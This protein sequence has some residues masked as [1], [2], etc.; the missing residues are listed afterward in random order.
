VKTIEQ[1][2][3]AIVLVV[4]LCIAAFTANVFLALQQ[5]SEPKVKTCQGDPVE[6]GGRP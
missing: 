3:Q 2:N 4:L 1:D 6:G 5:S